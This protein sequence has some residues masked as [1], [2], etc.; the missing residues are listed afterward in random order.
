MTGY[1]DIDVRFFPPPPELQGCF[2]TFYR[3]T[4]TMPDGGRV[5]DYLQPEWANLRFFS[6]DT[7]DARMIEGDRVTGARFT[8]TG[9]SVQ[10]GPD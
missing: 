9:P 1:C 3:A 6:G 2:S 4:F 10:P 8:A 7:P 5:R